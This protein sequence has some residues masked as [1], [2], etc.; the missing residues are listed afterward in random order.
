MSALCICNPSSSLKAKTVT[1]AFLLPPS[2]P[3]ARTPA[4]CLAQWGRAVWVQIPTST[5]LTHWSPW[6]RYLTS[7]YLNFLPYEMRLIINLT[8]FY[9]NEAELIY[10]VFG[11]TL[12]PYQELNTGV[13]SGIDICLPSYFSQQGTCLVSP[14]APH[15]A[16]SRCLLNVCWLDVRMSLFYK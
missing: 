2:D 5:M 1:G 16:C 7:L 12:G 11:R 6:T 9:E 15:L 14:P 8:T 3:W 13:I 10:T 4:V